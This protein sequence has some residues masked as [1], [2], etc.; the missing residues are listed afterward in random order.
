MAVH[1]ERLSTKDERE[2][3]SEQVLEAS[4]PRSPC[5]LKADVQDAIESAEKSLAKPPPVVIVS[6]VEGVEHPV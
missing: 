2:G 5:P 3:E 4:S 6:D 1:L